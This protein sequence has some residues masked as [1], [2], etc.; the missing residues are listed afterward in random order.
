MSI[1]VFYPVVRP[2]GRL[3]KRTQTVLQEC[4]AIFRLFTADAVSPA[5]SHTNTVPLSCDLVSSTAEVKGN[6]RELPYSNTH[7]TTS[8]CFQVSKPMYCVVKAQFCIMSSISLIYIQSTFLLYL[9]NNS[10][11][12]ADSSHLFCIACLPAVLMRQ[13]YWSSVVCAML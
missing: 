7:C 6:H 1:S 9:N 10:S 11:F 8:D 5:G 13:S 12:L 4:A 3:G 2:Q